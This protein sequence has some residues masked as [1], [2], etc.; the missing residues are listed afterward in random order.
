MLPSDHGIPHN[1]SQSKEH[2]RLRIVL[3]FVTYFLE[4]S[5]VLLQ[6]SI[7]IAFTIGIGT[8]SQ[9]SVPRS[10]RVKLQLISVYKELNSNCYYYLQAIAKR[11][12]ILPY[13]RSRDLRFSDQFCLSYAVLVV[14]EIHYILHSFTS[15]PLT[16]FL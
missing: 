4:S 2:M 15:Q 14:L 3:A 13:N 10:H 6:L 1:T 9:F 12:T 11:S 5:L 8:V 7:T 16:Y